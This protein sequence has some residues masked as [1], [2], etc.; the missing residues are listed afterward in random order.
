MKRF[1]LGLV[2]V[3]SGLFLPSAQVW[4]Q[5]ASS[6]SP[7]NS[8]L[9]C[10]QE[11]ETLVHLMLS[12]LAGYANRVMTRS[13]LSD[14]LVSYRTY[15]LLAGKP[16]FAPLDLTTPPTSTPTAADPSVQQVFFTTL[17]RQY[18]SDR[19]VDVQ[20][21]HRL[22]LVRTESGWRPVMLF[23][24]FGSS[25]PDQPP[26]PPQETSNGV[27]GRAVDLWLRDCRAGVI[28]T[29]VEKAEGE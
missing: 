1:F 2:A 28:R 29:R 17:E 4:G 6:P 14:R 13:R 11:V 23:T 20:N 5:V 18:S 16:E 12:D 15:I 7:A 10:P 22:L 3:A 24:R 19:V 27:I 21:Y 25:Q 9:S 26:L 8:T